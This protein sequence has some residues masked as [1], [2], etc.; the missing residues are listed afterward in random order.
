MDGHAYG[1][2]VLRRLCDVVVRLPAAEGGLVAG[3]VGVTT[4]ARRYR[5]AR[6]SS[7]SG[8]RSAA[9]NGDGQTGIVRPGVDH[10]RVA[11]A[12]LTGEQL[13][14]QLVTDVLCTSRRSGRAP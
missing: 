13:A 7:H 12:H 4:G 10:H 8:Q 11:V 9:T 3:S 6:P 14:S 2:R 5:S 1:D